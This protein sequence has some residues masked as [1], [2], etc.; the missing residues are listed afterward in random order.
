M[1]LDKNKIQTSI[2]KNPSKTF[3]KLQ[4]LFKD[5]FP[6]N[7]KTKYSLQTSSGIFTGD[8]GQIFTDETEKI[9]Y[10]GLG[11]SSKVKTRGIAQHFF[12]FGEK[13]RK[14]NGVGLEIHLPKI[15]TT[16]LPANLLVYQIINSLEQGAYAIN[17]LAK[18]FKENSKKIGN[19]SLI[20]QDAAKVKEAEKGLRRGKVVS[21]YVNGARFIAHLPANHFT[22]EDF[23]SR[24]KEIAKDNGLK[25]TVFD[26]PQL[27]KERWE[28]FSRSAKARIKRRR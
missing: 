3:Y 10:L 15:L 7:L 18:E 2:G 12:S 24:S 11:D 14:W 25:I 20:L 1:K 16:A 19:V 26:E 27:K 9:I 8:N 21:R 13:L 17:V 5:H 23:V 22:P 4:L 28:E 6:E